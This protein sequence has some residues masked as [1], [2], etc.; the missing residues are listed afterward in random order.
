MES[1]GI[2]WCLNTKVRLMFVKVTLETIHA[3]LKP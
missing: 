1:L 2:S 3:Y